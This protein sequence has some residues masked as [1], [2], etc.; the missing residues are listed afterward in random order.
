MHLFQAYNVSTTFLLNVKTSQPGLL[1]FC[2]DLVFHHF[3]GLNPQD[4]SRQMR[5]C[6]ITAR[7]TGQSIL[8]H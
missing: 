2:F 5:S 4:A 8:S 7:L 6:F 1:M 3:T